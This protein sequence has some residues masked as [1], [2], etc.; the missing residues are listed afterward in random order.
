MVYVS[1][2]KLT[3]ETETSL[4]I[5]N[6]YYTV[7][8]VMNKSYTDDY[9]HA[10]WLTCVSL[11][12]HQQHSNNS[13]VTILTGNVQCRKTIL[14]TNQIIINRQAVNLTLFWMFTSAF[15]A[16]TALTWPF[17]AY[18]A[19]APVC[20]IVWAGEPSLIHIPTHYTIP[21]NYLHL[22]IGITMETATIPK[23]II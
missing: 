3:A 9:N 8:M 16:T 21:H 1:S 20:K 11:G 15:A 4:H 23:N 7:A 5:T 19:V 6:G 13:T 14:C 17:W 22:S 2:E 12:L 10:L 18:N